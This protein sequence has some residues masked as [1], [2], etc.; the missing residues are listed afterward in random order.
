MCI[1]CVLEQLDPAS[2]RYRLVIVIGPSELGTSKLC[3]RNVDQVA[4]EQDLVLVSAE[5]ITHMARSMPRYCHRQQMI[6]QPVPSV[7]WGKERTK[8]SQIWL[9]KEPL[10]GVLPYHDLAEV[11]K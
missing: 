8:L 5:E 11:V 3:S 6:G 10:N 2:P 9:G 7:D 1:R 4:A